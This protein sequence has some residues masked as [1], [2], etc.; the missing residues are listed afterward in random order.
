MIINGI[1][2]TMNIAQI[3]CAGSFAGS[4]AVACGLARALQSRADRSVLYVVQE[5]RAGRE[6]CAQLVQRAREFDV[7]L[8]LFE[9]EQRFSR[10][11]LAQLHDALSGD[12]IDIVHNHSYKTAFLCPM[13]R[14]IGCMRELRV[15]FTI[16]GFD[17]S[18]LKGAASLHTYNA[19]GAYL[20]DGLVCV[21][22]PLADHL[23]P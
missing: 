8:R 23:P 11:L 1:F 2:K 7:E 18:T 15:F 22:G 5:V 13:L 6:S 10:K 9:T 20:C 12:A 14:S 19:L 17:Q 16:H 21:S 3:L 4:E